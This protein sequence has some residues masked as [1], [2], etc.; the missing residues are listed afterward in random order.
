V[1]TPACQDSDPEL[2]FPERGRGFASPAYRA[3]YAEAAAVCASCPIRLKC[4]EDNLDVPDGVWG[5]LDRH[6]RGRLLVGQGR[7][8]GKGRAQFRNMSPFPNEHQVLAQ[9]ARRQAEIDGDVG[10]MSDARHSA[11]R[12]ARRRE[13]RRLRREELARSA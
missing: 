9:R 3:Q 6:D 13:E 5:G 10:R 7:V 4:L 8:N 1:N 12:N 11:E 2:F